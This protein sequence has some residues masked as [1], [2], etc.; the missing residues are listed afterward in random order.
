MENFL[1]RDF[2]REALARSLSMPESVRWALVLD[3]GRAVG[4]CKMNWAR[5]DP[6]KGERGAELQ[7]IYF[8]VDEAG[9]GH[10]AAAM[11]WL[12]SQAGKQQAPAGRRSAAGWS[13]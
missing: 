12:L 10:G 11:A 3:A 1:E 6:I 5:P 4:F 7:K 8:L 2:S 13:R 9:K